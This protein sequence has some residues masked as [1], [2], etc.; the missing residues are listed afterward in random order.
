MVLSE[1]LFLLK[2]DTKKT[3]DEI[4][5]ISA[6]LSL[7]EKNQDALIDT[8]KKLKIKCDSI[9]A[10]AIEAVCPRKG[11]EEFSP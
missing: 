5:S 7:S 1:E 8:M 3:E 4:A 11:Y 10:R 9:R 6:Q 2:D